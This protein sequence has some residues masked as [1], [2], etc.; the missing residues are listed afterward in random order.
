MSSFA[1]SSGDWLPSKFMRPPRQGKILRSH[2]ARSCPAR[3][4]IAA[5]AKRSERRSAAAQKFGAELI[6]GLRLQEAKARPR[7]RFAGK[8][9][10]RSTPGCCRTLC[11]RTDSGARPG[12]AAPELPGAHRSGVLGLN[13]RPWRGNHRARESLSRLYRL[14]LT[15]ISSVRATPQRRAARLIASPTTPTWARLNGRNSITCRSPVAI[16]TCAPVDGCDLVDLA[17]PLDSR[18]RRR[19]RRSAPSRRRTHARASSGAASGMPK[20]AMTES[21]RNW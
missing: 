3:G 2:S 12:F 15:T 10:K 21:P 9:I 19:C 5:A 16:A 20:I 18:R 13:R 14:L 1:S 11:R 17:L 4:S 7:S 6:D 8:W